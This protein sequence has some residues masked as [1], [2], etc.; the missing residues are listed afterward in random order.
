M[1]WR[2]CRLWCMML[3]AMLIAMLIGL[4]WSGC[5]DSKSI[6]VDTG[7]PD[8]RGGQRI[9]PLASIPKGERLIFV[10]KASRKIYIE[11]DSIEV[12]TGDI[13][14]MNPDGSD[15]IQHTN[16]SQEYFVTDHPRLSYNGQYLTFTSNY[17]SWNS[18]C[19]TD[20]FKWD[21]VANRIDRVSGDEWPP[22]SPPTRYTTVK[23]LCEATGVRLSA[24]GCGYFIYPQQEVQTDSGT[25]YRSYLKVPAS[26]SI[27]IK[28][29]KS[30]TYGDLVTDYMVSSGDN[31]V[32]IGPDPYT[33]SGTV[34][35]TQKGHIN[36]Q[37]KIVGMTSGKLTMWKED[38]TII[39][40]KNIG[41]HQWGFSDDP[42]WSHD[43]SKIA[44][45]LGLTGYA[46]FLAIHT[47]PE[48]EQIPTPIVGDQTGNSICQWPAWSPDDQYLIFCYG[49]IGGQGINP[50]IYRIS[51][52]GGMPEM[53]THFNGYQAAFNPC[54]SPDGSK[55]VFTVMTCKTRSFNDYLDFMVGNI[56]SA[57]IWVMNL[58]GSDL[59]QLTTDGVSY[60]ATWGTVQ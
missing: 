26:T 2:C 38:G 47:P 4:T 17:R 22:D 42:V 31:E 9:E 52:N 10:K 50:N 6:P 33:E 23:I 29:E 46:N 59:R 32:V 48:S 27:W 24:K 16:L 60:N 11:P 49:P 3:I 21:L 14:S 13:W 51:V 5:A 56:E 41:G 30:S 40:E 58:D 55:I 18:C 44:L 53:L 35:I 1:R 37:G 20:I 54:Y 25:Y 15:P 43:G 39:W 8:P 19:Y 28:S 7:S 45:C 12:G 57:T 34:L 36:D